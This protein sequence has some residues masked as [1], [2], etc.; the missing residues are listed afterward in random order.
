MSKIC[1]YANT[2]VSLMKSTN[3][4]WLI[5]TH[6]RQEDESQTMRLRWDVGATWLQMGLLTLPYS[7]VK[8]KH[9]YIYTC[10]YRKES[11][12]VSSDNSASM[13]IMWYASYWNSCCPS[14]FYCSMQLYRLNNL[15]Q[16]T[17][18]QP[19]SKINMHFNNDQQMGITRLHH[20]TDQPTH[21]I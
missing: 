11:P 12:S 17:T 21:F 20:V 2:L 4:H 14:F 1:N 3:S 7:S 5:R 9:Y 13:L 15:K 19:A 6:L 18:K 16:P 8:S 10:R